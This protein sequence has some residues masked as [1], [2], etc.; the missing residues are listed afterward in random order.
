MY[1]CIYIYVCVRVCF[2]KTKVGSTMFNLHHVNPEVFCHS[3][4]PCFLRGR[5]RRHPPRLASGRGGLCLLGSHLHGQTRGLQWGKPLRETIVP[6]HNLT[7]EG[8]L[9]AI[10]HKQL[11]LCTGRWRDQM[12]GL[13]ANNAEKLHIGSWCLGWSSNYIAAGGTRLFHQ[14][15]MVFALTNQLGF[16]LTQKKC[17]RTQ[18]FIFKKAWNPVQMVL[19]SGFFRAIS[20]RCKNIMVSVEFGSFPLRNPCSPVR[21]TNS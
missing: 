5:R 20:L 1:V 21:Q 13:V 3:I 16:K 18:P 19:V 6:S 15:I 9:K 17:A 14:P 2:R 10:K 12:F 7:Y 8:F 4:S 11:Q